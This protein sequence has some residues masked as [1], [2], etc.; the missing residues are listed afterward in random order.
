M[1]ELEAKRG[2]VLE[3]GGLKLVGR[4]REQFVQFIDT[5]FSTVPA[6]ERKSRLERILKQAISLWKE[7]QRPEYELIVF[8]CFGRFIWRPEH[9]WMV[10]GLRWLMVVFL[11]HCPLRRRAP[12]RP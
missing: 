5:S 10:N 11:W 4:G 9:S 7:I 2:K 3:V 1:D 12:H 8:R 6:P